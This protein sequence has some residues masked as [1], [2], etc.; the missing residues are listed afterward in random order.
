MAGG[1]SSEPCGLWPS[2]G[3][4][5]SESIGGH[6]EIGSR[7]EVMCAVDVERGRTTEVTLGAAAVV[8]VGILLLRKDMVARIS[9]TSDQGR[10]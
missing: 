10:A 5:F 4:G 1:R 9:C 8:A 3:S 2:A 7:G 6:G